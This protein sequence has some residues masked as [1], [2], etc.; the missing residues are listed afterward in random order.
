[1]DL[2]TFEVDTVTGSRSSTSSFTSKTLSSATS[3]LP[4]PTPNQSKT[5][6]DKMGQQA[7]NDA[8]G[9]GLASSQSTLGQLSYGPATQTTVVTTT[10]TTTTSLAP[11]VLKPPRQLNERDP[12]L[13]PLA[14]TPTPQSLRKVSFNVEGHQAY[15]REAESPARE[16]DE[17]WSFSSVAASRPCSVFL[18]SNPDMSSPTNSLPPSS[19]TSYRHPF[20]PPMAQS[21][22]HKSITYRSRH[23]LASRSNP[24]HERLPSRKQYRPL[25]LLAS[26]PHPQSR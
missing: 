23:Q 2:A 25:F 18:A 20:N 17:V 9:P 12:K 3:P 21:K 22:R 11:M 15:F 13:Y 5:R 4:D 10:T 24:Y 1:M 8:G 7:G 6:V 19:I 16:F 26:V 14:S